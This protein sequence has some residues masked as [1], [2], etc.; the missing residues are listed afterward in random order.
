MRG[1]A[2]GLGCRRCPP[3]G[4]FLGLGA[5]ACFHSG[6]WDGLPPRPVTGSL[7]GATPV[8]SGEGRWTGA[9]GGRG[10]QLPHSLLR[11]ELPPQAGKGH[12]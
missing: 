12:V 4:R 5:I 2:E 7:L 8:S 1:S 6:E 3:R 9:W 11:P 10:G